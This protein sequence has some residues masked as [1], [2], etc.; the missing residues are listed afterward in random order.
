MDNYKYSL[1]QQGAA[2]PDWGFA[3]ILLA[4]VAVLSLI[5][6]VILLIAAVQ[7]S[8]SNGLAYGGVVLIASL[9]FSGFA[10]G[11]RTLQL[12]EWRLAEWRLSVAAERAIKPVA[13]ARTTGM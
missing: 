13:I 1:E 3:S 5:A 10:S 7:D 9:L 2:R 12:I 4:V 11:L 6:G 8:N